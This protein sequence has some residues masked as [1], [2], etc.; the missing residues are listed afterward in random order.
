MLSG[1]EYPGM[2][3]ARGQLQLTYD[4]CDTNASCA[5]KT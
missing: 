2:Q 1:R 4:N 5:I 3:N